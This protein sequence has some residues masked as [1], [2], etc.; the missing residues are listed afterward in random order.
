MAALDAI[1][2]SH[3][4]DTL[5]GGDDKSRIEALEIQMIIG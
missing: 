1:L 3:F 4:K 5:R 2:F